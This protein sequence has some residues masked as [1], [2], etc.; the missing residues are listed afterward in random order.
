MTYLAKKL[1]FDLIGCL[2]K[3]IIEEKKPENI[4]KYLSSDAV[5]TKLKEHLREKIKLEVIEIKKNYIKHI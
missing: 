1:T 5:R 3:K 4:L 2:E